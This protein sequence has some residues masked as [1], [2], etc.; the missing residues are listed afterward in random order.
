[1][2]LLSTNQL[3]LIKRMLKNDNCL[4]QRRMAM[5]LLEM[6]EIDDLLDKNIIEKQRN[7]YDMRTIVY[8]IPKVIQYELENLTEKNTVILNK[9]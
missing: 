6:E 3:V 9:I 1:M 8:Q 5:T 4:I 2:V 7:I